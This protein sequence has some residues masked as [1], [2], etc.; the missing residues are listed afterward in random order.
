MRVRDFGF[1]KELEH[2]DPDG[3]SIRDLMQDE[4]QPHEREMADYLAKGV[5]VFG[6]SGVFRDVISGANRVI[7]AFQLLTDGE[8]VWPSDLAYYVRTYHVVI[9]P[10]L[11]EHMQRNGWRVPELSGEDLVRIS[12]SWVMQ[13]SDRR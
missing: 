3:P 11:A 13:H 7:G 5:P 2:G 12:R 6:G 10:E 8:W 9:P 4:P 1:F